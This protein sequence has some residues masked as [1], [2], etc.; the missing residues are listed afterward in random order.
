MMH[1]DCTCCE[2]CVSE[3]LWS[4]NKK[5][6]DQKEKILSL[7][8]TIEILKKKVLDLTKE[9]SFLNNLIDD[10]AELSKRNDYINGFRE[11]Y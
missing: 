4:A 3:S 6:L 7:E 2:Q 11:S 9:N 5:V 10:E 8:K 1:I